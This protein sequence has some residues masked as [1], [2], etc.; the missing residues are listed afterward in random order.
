VTTGEQVYK[1]YL[2]SNPV[3]FTFVSG[4]NWW[5]YLKNMGYYALIL[6][7]SKLEA[8]EKE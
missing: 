2:E 8:S 4:E 6:P 5:T 7:G 1:K 3:D